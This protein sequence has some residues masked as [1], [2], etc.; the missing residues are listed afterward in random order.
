MKRIKIAQ[1]TSFIS[2]LLFPI[3]LN[4]FSPYV[5]VTGA[6]AG[7]V[8][9]SIL[10]FATMLITA[11]FFRRAWCSFICPV[12]SIA[13]AAESVN[14]KAVDRKTLRILRYGIFA[15]WFG[16]LIL[17][18]VLANGVHA[19]VP[20]YMTE[21][22][23]SVDEPLKYITYLSVLFILVALTFGLGK[24][25]ACHSICWMSP[26]LSLGA[27]LGD[28]LH[29]PQYK[30]RSQPDLCIS[31]QRCDRNCPMSIDVMQELKKG[32]IQTQDCIQCGRCVEVCPKSVF[33]IGFKSNL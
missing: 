33:S 25:G 21:A 20:L 7:I 1:T 14:P 24:R 23:I 3:T 22:G 18:F 5:S 11:I 32:S 12:A 15:V 26:F 31:C 8:S 29:L 9:G 30:V 10:L 27:W 28:K 19:I 17:G 2:L 13:Y 16:V 6:F 4:F